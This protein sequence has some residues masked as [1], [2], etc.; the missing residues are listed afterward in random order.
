MREHRHG[1]LG[2][3]YHLLI[4]KM[5]KA[6]H[7]SRESLR[8]GSPPPKVEKNI[9]A[10]GRSCAVVENIGHPFDEF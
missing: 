2:K 8:L 5:E 7:S 3:G 1:S 6:V 10:D 9:F 4:P